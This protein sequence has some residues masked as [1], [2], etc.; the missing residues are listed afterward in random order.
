MSPSPIRTAPKPW[1]PS[2]TRIR[3]SGSFPPAATSPP[4]RPG[5]AQVRDQRGALVTHEG[6]AGVARFE[7]IKSG[8]Q[9][10]AD[11]TQ[12]RYGKSALHPPRH[13]R[14]HRMGDAPPGLACEIA[15]AEPQAP[16]IPPPRKP[17]KRFPGLRMNR[18]T[19]ELEIALLRSSLA[20]W[21][22]EF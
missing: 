13:R 11:G 4:S 6:P 18:T 2:G 8:L 10:A 14:R 21:S 22:I 5:S 19:F 17:H 7:G 20:L 9:G 16:S 12:R 15:R 3:N 1:A